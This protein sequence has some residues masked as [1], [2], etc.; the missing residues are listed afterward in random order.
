MNKNTNDLTE[1][2]NGITHQYRRALDAF[3]QRTGLAPQRVDAQG[4]GEEREQIARMDA[5][6]TL[7]E[8][9]RQNAELAA[10]NAMLSKRPTLESRAGAGRLTDANDA[11]TAAYAARWLKAVVSGNPAEMRALSLSSSNA[12]IPTDMERRIVERLQQVNVL[13]N[14]AVVRTINSK[15]SIAVENALPTTNL[16]TE[17]SSVSDSDPTFSTAISVVP[18]KLVTRTTLSQEFIEDAIGQ[19]DPGTGLQYVADRLA[20]SMGLKQEEFYTAGTGSSQPQGICGTGSGISQTTDLGSGAAL[21]TV[22]ADNLIDTVHLCPVQYRNSPRFRWLISDAFLRAVR[23]LKNAVTTSGATEYIWSPGT[24]NANSLVG[25]APAT[26]YGVPYSVGQYV[27][28]TTG[29]G[30]TYAVVG[31]FSYFEIFDRTGITSMTDPY[32]AMSTMQTNLYVFSRTDS[33]VML[34]A[35]F[36][37]IIG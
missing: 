5:D 2:L 17:G 28:T 18:Y 36:A 32:S 29:N 16:V 24:A 15:R 3:E 8:L 13:R 11:D 14:I 9:R 4:S 37:N 19:G 21:T 7:T 35:A 31:D 26:I 27:P 25:G 33:K 34:P 22:T 23:K 30:T 10:Q 6:L 1:E 12:A 20:T